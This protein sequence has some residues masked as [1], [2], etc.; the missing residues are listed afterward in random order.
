MSYI[1]DKHTPFRTYLEEY[2]PRWDG[3]AHLRRDNGILEVRFHTDNG[4]ARFC[5]AMHAGQLGLLLD[6]SHDPDTELVIVTGTGSTYLA[7]SDEEMSFVDIEYS[8]NVTYDWW[9]LNA[10][11]V[12]L[13]WLDVPVPVICAV[14]GP[15]TIHPESVLLSDYIIAA[16]TAYTVDRHLQDAGCAPIDGINILYDKLLGP[17]AGRAL[18]MNGGVI[19]AK[20]AHELGMVAEVVPAGEELDRAWQF[21]RDYLTKVP[22]RIVRRMTRETFTQP[23]REAFMKDIRSSLVHECYSSVLRTDATPDAG[24]QNM[25]A[26]AQ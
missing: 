8:S 19:E 21:A 17:N 5:E 24:H 2:A 4:P 10:T 7:L 23:L 22:S 15:Y 9:Y 3:M 26:S 1:Y 20:R 11:R 6:I 14:N 18:L 12:P 16:D 25:V 13:A